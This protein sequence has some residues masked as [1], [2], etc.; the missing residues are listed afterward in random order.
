MS[1]PHMPT[2]FSFWDH[3]IESIERALEIR[4]KIEALKQSVSDI[5]G[6]TK[7]KAAKV[8]GAKISKGKVDGRRGKRSAATRAKMAAAAKARWA[9]RKA[10]ASKTVAKPA[11]PA[12]AK[13]KRRKMS[14]EARAKIAAAQRARWA[15]AKSA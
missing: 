5:M 4:K 9:A 14:P 3:P 2:S 10:G 1:Y 15:K 6:D 7:A 8:I 12:K 11:K 13:R